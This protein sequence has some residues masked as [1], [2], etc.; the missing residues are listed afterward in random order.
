MREDNY[1]ALRR[2]WEGQTAYST[3][4]DAVVTVQKVHDPLDTDV[5]EDPVAIDV[6]TPDGRLE[7]TSLGTIRGNRVDAVP[8]DCQL[9][10]QSAHEVLTVLDAG[11][12]AVEAD[13]DDRA[14]RARQLRSVIREL[15]EVDQAEARP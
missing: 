5:E 7:T 4:F 6:W 10:A 13:S 2:V 14:D 12:D 8:L 3:E 1:A 15:H 9:C 11:I